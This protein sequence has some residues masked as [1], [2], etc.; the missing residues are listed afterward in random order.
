MV[1]N[2]SDMGY[3]GYYT[4]QIFNN[5]KHPE[6][7]M[8]KILLHSFFIIF[9]LSGLIFTGTTQA[10][11]KCWVNN[12]GVRECGNRIP[13]EYA[14]KEHSELGKGGL[15]RKKNEGAKSNKELKEAE[16]LEKNQAKQKEIIA[17]ERMQDEMLLARFTS[18]N[19][20]EEALDERISA[21]DSVIELTKTRNEK[22]EIDLNKRI[23]TV[24]DANK[25]GNTYPESLI[26]NIESLKRQL[27][28][29]NSF[30]E[31]RYAERED[32]KIAHE[33]DIRRFKKLKKIK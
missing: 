18:I 19:E 22:I 25:T 4:Y 29:N 8:K 6:K 20:I 17:K 15:I 5:I 10:R 33:L 23:Q 21:L 24:S 13:P 30:M 14:Q 11:V 28:N 27:S 2:K 1:Q 31:E 9:A 32:I 16:L 26:K 3:L 7:F 12:D